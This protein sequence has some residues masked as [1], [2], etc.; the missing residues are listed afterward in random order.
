MNDLTVTKKKR[1]NVLNNKYA[2]A[3][4]Q[5]SLSITD[6]LFDYE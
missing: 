4:I 3:N 2:I 5:N 6:M 1:Q